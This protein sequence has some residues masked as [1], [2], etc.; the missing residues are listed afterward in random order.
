MKKCV[1]CNPLPRVVFLLPGQIGKD[2]SRIFDGQSN[3]AL[4]SG[5]NVVDGIVSKFSHHF[6]LSRR[7]VLARNAILVRHHF[8]VDG[9][10]GGCR[11]VL[12]RLLRSP[13]HVGQSI[14]KVTIQIRTTAND[15]FAHLFVGH[16][17]VHGSRTVR[18]IHSSQL[19]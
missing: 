11:T 10:C 6:G 15:V 5:F 3:V 2:D 8:G 19:R 7:N 14:F 18:P 4:V 16:R 17:S 12:A 9:G 13:I 1:C